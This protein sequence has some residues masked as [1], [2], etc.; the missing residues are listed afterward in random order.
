M[1]DFVF[2]DSKNLVFIELKRREYYLSEKSKYLNIICRKSACLVSFTS[3]S[4]N[5]QHKAET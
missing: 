4:Y 5:S 3:I 1:N 2:V